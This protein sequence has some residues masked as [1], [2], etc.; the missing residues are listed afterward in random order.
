LKGKELKAEAIRL[1]ISNASKMKADDLRRY[2][3]LK[4][5]SN[6]LQEAEANT[7]DDTWDIL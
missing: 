1:N 3:S 2:I 6:K 7:D 5:D 4:L